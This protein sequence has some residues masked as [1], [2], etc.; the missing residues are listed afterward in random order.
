MSTSLPSATN[1]TVAPSHDEIAQCA[2]ELWTEAGHPEGRDD[3]FWY[4]GEQRLLAARQ[5]PN[6]SA[7]MVATLAQ[8]VTRATSANEAT[9]E[10]VRRTR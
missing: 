10:K 7:V 9:P 8:P 1:A 4:E 3:E 5:V 2:R 6:V